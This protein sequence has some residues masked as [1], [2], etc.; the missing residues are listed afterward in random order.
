M[1]I[2]VIFLLQEAYL[3]YFSKLERKF[4]FEI[5]MIKSCFC[6][7]LVTFPKTFRLVSILVTRLTE[8]A[9]G[10]PL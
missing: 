9:I 2:L 1:L 6:R 10:G 4:N 5:Q 3:T 8:A 7:R